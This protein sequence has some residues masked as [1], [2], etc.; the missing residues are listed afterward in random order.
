MTCDFKVFVSCITTAVSLF[1]FEPQATE[2]KPQVRATVKGEK[3]CLG[4]PGG[5][6]VWEKEAPGTITLR[7]HIEWTYTNPGAIPLILPLRKDSM[8]VVRT[9]N[10]DLDR[11]ERL[12]RFTP[13]VPA[14]DVTRGGTEHPTGPDFEVIPP[15]EKGKSM[16]G[17]NVFMTVHTLSSEQDR[18]DLLGTKMFL[19]LELDHLQFSKQLADELGKKWKEYGY[20]WTGKVRT[21]PIEIDVP[22]APNFADCSHEHKVD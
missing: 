21:Q 4:Q 8:L 7:F 5:V 19:Q 17:E 2:I 22:L 10:R 15:G 9:A 6:L 3:Y 20:L 14:V 13:R 1:G 12:I 16:F 11:N 18:T